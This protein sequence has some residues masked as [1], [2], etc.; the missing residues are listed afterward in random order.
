MSPEQAGGRGHLWRVDSLE[1]TGAFGPQGDVGSPGANGVFV[2][3][4]P[5]DL[6][7]VTIGADHPARVWDLASGMP[8]SEPLRHSDTITSAEFALDAETLVTTSRDGTAQ[9]WNVRTGRARTPPLRHGGAVLTAI[10]LSGGAGLVT[11][12]EEKRLKFWDLASGNL[13]RTVEG[14]YFGSTP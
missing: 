3:L 6:R 1:Q 2:K 13:L 4:S 12:S 10:V 14:D 9:V 11:L 8:L 7:V 5:D